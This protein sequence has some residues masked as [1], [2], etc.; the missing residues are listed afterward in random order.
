MDLTINEIFYSIQ[1]EGVHAGLPMAFIRFQGCNMLPPCAWCDTAYAQKPISGHKMSIEEVIARIGIYNPS[2]KSWVCITGGEPLWQWDGLEALLR[3]LNKY[4][5]FI[6][7]ETNGSVPKPG[8]YGFA[9]SWSIDI[10]CPSSGVCGTSREEW[11]ETRVTDQVKFVVGNT[12][13]LA[14]ARSMILRHR[15]DNPEVLVSPVINLDDRFPSIMWEEARPWLNEV[16]EFCKD[17][18]VRYS[19]Q[20]HKVIWGNKKGV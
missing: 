20:L 12:E 17:M 2:L 16:V 18:K 15:A 9:T 10:K 7:V 11:F 3:E 8:W 14:F 19:L 6:T 13:D 1:G 4:N 5:F